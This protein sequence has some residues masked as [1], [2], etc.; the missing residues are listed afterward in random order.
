MVETVHAGEF[1]RSGHSQRNARTRLASIPE[2]YSAAAAFAAGLR[3][4][5]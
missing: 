3:S 1:P 2:A 4:V 5:E